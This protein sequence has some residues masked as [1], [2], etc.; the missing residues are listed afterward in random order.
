METEI[1]HFSCKG[2]GWGEGAQEQGKWHNQFNQVRLPSLEKP[3]LCPSFSQG[4]TE[5]QFVARKTKFFPPGNSRPAN[6]WKYLWQLECCYLR[7][8]EEAAWRKTSKIN[9]LIHHCCSS[10]PA[11]RASPGLQRQRVTF[12]RSC[13]AQS[14]AL[15]A[16]R[17][18]TGRQLSAKPG[19]GWAGVEGRL[20]QDSRAARVLLSGGGMNQ[21]EM[22]VLPE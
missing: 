3:S 5:L 13:S 8:D 16:V 7:P 12:T 15:A 18:R 14:G 22:E 20:E 21:P 4:I 10:F 2:E 1:R 17:R 11:I 9:T 6:F 19:S